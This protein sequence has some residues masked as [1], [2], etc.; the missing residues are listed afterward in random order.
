M[1]VLDSTPVRLGEE[2]SPSP[3]GTDDEGGATETAQAAEATTGSESE[4]EVSIKSRKA[5]R[6]SDQK[7]QARRR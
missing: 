3:P 7:R 1:A 5:A 6:G 4:G 2:D